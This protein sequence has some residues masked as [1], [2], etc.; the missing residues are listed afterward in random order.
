MSC[1]FM[2]CTLV[3]Q[4]QVLHFHVLH[5]Q[6]P[7]FGVHFFL[8]HPVYVRPCLWS[9]CLFVCERLYE[10]VLNSLQRL[11]V[12][13]C[14]CAFLQVRLHFCV[15]FLQFLDH[16]LLIPNRYCC[17]CSLYLPCHST[18]RRVQ[19]F[20]TS[21]PLI[22]QRETCSKFMN[23]I[24]TTRWPNKNRTFLRYHIFAATT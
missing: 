3:R 23:T 19:E 20:A 10:T 11:Q 24:N 1:N 15:F 9:V 18:A 4:F 5:F 7:P 14:F 12:R 13:L 16:Q 22:I 17:C 8:A 6:R 2:P 21:F